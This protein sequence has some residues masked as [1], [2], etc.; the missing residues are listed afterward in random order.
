MSPPLLPPE[1]RP[2]LTAGDVAAVL[3]V[4]RRTVY[5]LHHAGQLRGARIGRSLRWSPAAVSD[6]LLRNR[7]ATIRQP[8]SMPPT[9]TGWRA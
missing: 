2:T 6:Y 7:V 9:R 3:R 8:T 1:R 4:D 5:R